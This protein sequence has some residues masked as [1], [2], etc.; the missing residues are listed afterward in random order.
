MLKEKVAKMMKLAATSMMLALG[1]VA[2]APVATVQA[3]MLQEVEPNNSR[4][5]ANVLP[6]NTAVKGI[7]ESGDEDWY[8]FTITQKGP[9]RIQIVPAEDNTAEDSRWS[10]EVQDN[11][12]NVL[13]SYDWFYTLTS[14]QISLAP[15]TYYVKVRQRG[16]WYNTTYNVR[17]IHEASDEWE[18]DIYYRYK[19]FANANIVSLNKT[20]TGT[21]YCYGDVD[22]YHFKLNGINNVSF[23]FN[24]DDTV[25]N[26]GCWKIEFI[27][28]NTKNILKREE[29][30]TNKII[31]SGSCNGDLVVR[32]SGYSSAEAQPYHIQAYVKTSITPTP[33]VTPQPTVAPTNP[34]NNNPTT[35]VQ[36][37]S[38][39]KIT[40]IKPGKKQATIRWKKASNA[41]GYYVYRST[42]AKGGYKKIA[43]V[44]GKTTYKDKKA[45]KS[46][47]TYYYKVISY[48]KNGSKVLK[49]K[50]S[51]YKRVKI[52]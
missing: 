50:A 28:Y 47:K 48:R 42:K 27:E 23:R 8:K 24:I 20:Y 19:S 36:K 41:T 52:K 12:R 49:S 40:S 29:I 4:A 6:L 2:V 43:T 39:T 35:T 13:Y 10:V 18:Q 37:P 33:T 9:F 3:D 44:N 17:A 32:I 26:P 25:S 16:S 14:R 46:K 34:S 7:S 38:A 21:M 1:V 15:G 45:L 22:Y 30:S 31:D 5:E 51:G 11:D